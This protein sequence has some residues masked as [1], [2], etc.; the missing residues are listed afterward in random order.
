MSPNP[1]PFEKDILTV[2]EAAE[3]LSCS[4]SHVVHL[5]TGKVAGVS[6]IPHVKAGRLRRIRREALMRWFREQ[7]AI[8]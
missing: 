4:Y 1:T 7:E 6:P 3:I 8:Q 5:L 2:H